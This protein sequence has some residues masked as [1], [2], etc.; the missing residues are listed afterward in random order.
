[1]LFCY[2]KKGDIYRCYQKEQL[3]SWHGKYD[4]VPPGKELFSSGIWKISIYFTC[5]KIGWIKYISSYDII[6][7]FKYYNRFFDHLSESDK[8]GDHL[9]NTN[10]LSVSAGYTVPK[11]ERLYLF[12]IFY[13]NLLSY[14]GEVKLHNV[15]TLASKT[16]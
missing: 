5:L 8:T 2:A 10:K 13:M 16:F 12:C 15:A 14:A 9:R 11:L 1:M 7:R 4:T 3:S 6:E